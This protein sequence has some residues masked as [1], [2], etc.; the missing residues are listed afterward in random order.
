MESMSRAFGM[1]SMFGPSLFEA[2]ELPAMS[3]LTAAKSLAV[4]IK[5]RCSALRC[6]P[7]IGGGERGGSCT[8]PNA[9]PQT[10]YTSF[11]RGTIIAPT[12]S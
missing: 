11:N 10:R 12:C 6:L 5:V 3:A 1:P 7:A 9:A 2:P 4:D 8:V